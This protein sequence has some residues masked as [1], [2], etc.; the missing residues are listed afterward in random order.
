VDLLLRR[1]V[2]HHANRFDVKIEPAI[3]D[4]LDKAQKSVFFKRAVQ[5]WKTLN[6]SITNEI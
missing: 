5:I 6:A 1:I 2:P 3:T 4:I